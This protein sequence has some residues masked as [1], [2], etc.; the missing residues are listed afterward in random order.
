MT[1]SVGFARKLGMMIFESNLVNVPEN[2]WWIDSGASV[3]ISC[4]LHGFLSQRKSRDEDRLV[5][6]NANAVHVEA[7]GTSQLVLDTGFCLE[8]RDVFYVPAFRTN[9][10]SVSKLDTSGYLVSFDNGHV[11]IYRGNDL[12]GHGCLVDGLHQLLLHDSHMSALC[13][14]ADFAFVGS[15]RA[16]AIENSSMLWHRR[17]GHVS[18]K[19]LKSLVEN[20]IIGPLDFSDFDQCMDCVRGKMPKKS[21]FVASRA[22]GL[23]DLIHTDIC[24]FPTPS[25]GGQRYFVSFI[26]DFSRYAYVYLIHQKSEALDMFKIYQTEVEK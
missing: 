7:V 8:L 22:L 14:S 12:V 13:F 5:L 11:C 26:D 10:V 4:S 6:G 1:S 17:L 3:H 2:T 20:G 25:R 15:K 19:R 9:L 23:L 16:L 24:A 18:K 21:N